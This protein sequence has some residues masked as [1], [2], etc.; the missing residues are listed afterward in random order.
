MALIQMNEQHAILYRAW[1][2]YFGES[3]PQTRTEAY[4]R[5]REGEPV[6]LMR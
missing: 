3:T 1:L 4:F 6:P 5:S 2:S